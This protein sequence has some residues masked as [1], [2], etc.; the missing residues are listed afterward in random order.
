MTAAAATQAPPAVASSL[1]RNRQAFVD[2]LRGLAAL[3]V[4]LFHLS[5]GHHIDA[6]KARL[7][8]WLVTGVFD[9]GHLGVAIFFV[10]SGFVMALTIERA[11]VDFGYADRFLLRRFLRVTPPYWFTVVFCALVLEAKARATGQPAPG[12]GAQTLLAHALYVQDMAGIDNINVV[13]WTL[14]IEVQ[15]YVAFALLAWLADSL[16]GERLRRRDVRAGVLG[17]AALLALAWPLHLLEANP[18][19]GGFLPY[20][21]AF[22]AGVFAFWGWTHKG[23]LL[24]GA[25]GYALVLAGA[26][27]VRH[28]SF[29]V[30]AALTVAAILLSGLRDGMDRWLSARPLQFIGLVSYSLY[31]L[32]NPLTGMSYRVVNR[33]LPGGGPGVEIAGACMT[34]AVCLGAAWL[35]FLA[36]ER[37]GIRLAHAIRLSR[38]GAAR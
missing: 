1:S 16:A 20:W 27:L 37:P 31:L 10:L 38:P 33:L 13:F 25:V 15:F 7:P 30:I 17:A 8:A 18:W 4:M 28:D 35:C 23:W 36:V 2:G 34:V 22:L 6:L 19:R 14:C 29:A 21:Y 32:H 9:M 3:W 24:A 12:I 11:V 5:E 26:G